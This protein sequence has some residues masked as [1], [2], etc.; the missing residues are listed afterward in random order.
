MV[1]HSPARLIASAVTAAVILA[2]CSAGPSRTVA[3]NGRL[4]VVAAEDFWGSLARQLGGDRADVSSLLSNPDADPHDYEPTPNDA[5]AVASARYVIVNGI[6]YDPWVDKLLSANRSSG[7]TVLNVGNV[8]GLQPGDNPHQWYSPAGVEEVIS[9]LTADLKKLDPADAAYFDQQRDNLESV[10]LADYKATIAD[11]KSRYAGTPVGASENI[12]RPLTDALGLRLVTP[13]R[14][15]DAISEGNEPTARDKSTV[16]QQIASTAIRV[17][18]FN[19]QNAT[20]DVRR[21]V[22]A[23]KAHGVAVTTVTET[24]VPRGATF[25]AWQTAQLRDLEAALAAGTGR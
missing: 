19:R 16:D 25:Q 12:V 17:F 11:I 3:S 21:L 14:F 20:P 18:M 24:L 23:A 15:L 6:G 13:P 2:A 10:G 1:V 5:R 4:T 9:Q 22:D 8:A 7:R